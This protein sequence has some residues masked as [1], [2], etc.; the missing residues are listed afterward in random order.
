FAGATSRPGTLAPWSRAKVPTTPGLVDFH[1]KSV[2]PAGN[3]FVAGRYRNE[4]RTGRT[5]VSLRL[6]TWGMGNARTATGASSAASRVSAYAS[7]L[8]VVPRSI[9]TT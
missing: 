8:L 1:G 6:I 2:A 5:P 3:Y 9:P 7:A 4:G